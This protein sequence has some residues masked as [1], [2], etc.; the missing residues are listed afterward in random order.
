MEWSWRKVREKNHYVAQE[1]DGQCPPSALGVSYT[2]GHAA[3]EPLTA[4]GL[5]DARITLGAERVRLPG[6]GVAI[7]VIV[8]E[9]ERAGRD[10]AVAQ[11]A[12]VIDGVV[13]SAEL[14]VDPVGPV[15]VDRVA[16]D[17]VIVGPEQQVDPV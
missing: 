4:C 8:L 3:R 17:E 2:A 14:Q 1:E 9:V 6:V 15:L 11:G 7:G 10:Q 16:L 12:V 5:L 13:G